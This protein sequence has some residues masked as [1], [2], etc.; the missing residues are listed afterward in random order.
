[1]NDEGIN[2]S[3]HRFFCSDDDD[4]ADSLVLLLLLLPVLFLMITTTTSLMLADAVDY[5][6]FAPFF[7]PFADTFS[8]DDGPCHR[9]ALEALGRFEPEVPPQDDSANDETPAAA[10]ATA[11]TLTTTAT[12]ANGGMAI[13]DES[14]LENGSI[15]NMQVLDCTRCVICLHMTP[16]FLGSEICTRSVYPNYSSRCCCY[17]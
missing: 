15:V 9:E 8:D 6:F 11:A 3:E 7:T 14:S 13:E 12:A 4:S 17:C 10:A 1:M 2:T 5:V 16:F